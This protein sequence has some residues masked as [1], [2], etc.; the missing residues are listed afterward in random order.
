MGACGKNAYTHFRGGGGA[1][2][3]KL[4]DLVVEEDENSFL[5][6]FFFGTRK[7]WG[8]GPIHY[9]PENGCVCGSI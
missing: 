8:G 4:F 9:C 5:S 1:E 6:H 7:E 3:I 2:A